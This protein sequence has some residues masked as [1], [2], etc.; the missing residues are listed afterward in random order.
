MF[1]KFSFGRRQLG[2]YF[3]YHVTYTQHTYIDCLT[4]FCAQGISKRI[5]YAKNSLSIFS[6]TIFSLSIIREKVKLNVQ[7]A[8]VSWISKQ[9]I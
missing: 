6:I 8:T 1:K 7:V 9:S 5:I 3:W 4:T 2:K